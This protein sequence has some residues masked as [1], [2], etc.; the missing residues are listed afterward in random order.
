MVTKVGNSK[1]NTLNG[2]SGSDLLIGRG[3]N[4]RLNGGGGSDI[5]NGGS[6]NDR[7]NGGTG[8]DI[9]IGGSGIDTAIFSGNLAA[10]VVSAVP[11][12]FQVS[13]PDGIDIVSGVEFLQ[14]ADQTVPAG[15]ITNLAPVALDDQSSTNADTIVAG[16]V[17]TNDSDPNTDAL[18]VSRVNGSTAQVGV[19]IVLPSGALLTVNANGTFSYNPNNAFAGVAQGTNAVDTFTYEVSDGKGG[20]D[21]ATAEI[22]VAGTKLNELGPLTLGVDTINGTVLNDIIRGGDDTFSAFDAIDGGAG[23][24]TLALTELVGALDTT[25]G[26]APNATVKNVEIATFT[27]VGAIVA[28]T[29][30]WTGLQTILATEAGGNSNVTITT[31]ANATS[32]TVNG[33]FNIAIT[34][35]S[36]ADTLASVTVN[37]INGATDNVTVNSSALTSLKVSNIIGTVT[38]GSTGALALDISNSALGIDDVIANSATSLAMTVS[39]TTSLDDI[40]ANAAASVTL[41]ANASITLDDLSATAA[42]LLTI[43]GAGAVL[44]DD[45]FLAPNASINA[46]SSSGGVKI[47]DQIALDVAF[48]GGSGADDIEVGATSRV[49]AMGTGDDR[50]QLNDDAL[51]GGSL[52]GGG[53][54]ADTLQMSYANAASATLVS[55]LENQISE[56]ERLSLLVAASATI[57]MANLDD[58]NHVTTAAGNVTLNLDNMSS[59]GTLV[60]TGQNTTVTDVDFAVNGASDVFNLSYVSGGGGFQHD[61]D[62]EGQS[63]ETVNISTAGT[64]PFS[65]DLQLDGTTVIN[66]SGSAGFNFVVAGSDINDVTTLNASGVI[67]TGGTGSVTATAQNGGGVSFTGGAGDDIFQGAGGGDALKGNAGND[68]LFGFGGSD[69]LIGDAGNDTLDGGGSEVDT[70]TGGANADT[71]IVDDVSPVVNQFD[72]VTDALVGSGDTFDFGALIADFENV[73]VLVNAGDGFVTVVTNALAQTG[74]LAWFQFGGNTYLVNDQGND[75]GAFNGAADTVVQLLGLKDL[76]A[77]TL[78]GGDLII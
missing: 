55:G 47:D 21:T 40:F 19:Q 70:L 52:S 6:G 66:L 59:G 41:N 67:G 71:F 44:I 49:I 46:S 29:S 18:S 39:G 35:A 61:V 22:L 30:T 34:D 33:G 13:G 17:L 1:K 45:V 10:Y 11:G 14:F 68:Q 16:N 77:S 54:T 23:T 9:L 63:V 38:A 57:N 58:I 12:G 62:L 60:L 24:D 76:A 20:T 75:N 69:N 2:S 32:V 73:A 27:S 51:G 72:T 43:N 31:N 37:G 53:G 78:S 25:A 8:N 48:T 65:G 50:V 26:A 7:L 15:F 3:G 36:A 28:D 42:S 74:D 5:L 56:F 4:D 64:S